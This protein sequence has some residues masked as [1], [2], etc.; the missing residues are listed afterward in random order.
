VTIVG[1]TCGN[2][3]P[4][5]GTRWAFL[6]VLGTPWGPSLSSWEREKLP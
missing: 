1:L 6:E 4:T 5:T 3:D 2:A